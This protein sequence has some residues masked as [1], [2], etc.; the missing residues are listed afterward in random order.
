M[1]DMSKMMVY[2]VGLPEGVDRDLLEAAVGT[3]MHFFKSRL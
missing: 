2:D 3:I 1:Y